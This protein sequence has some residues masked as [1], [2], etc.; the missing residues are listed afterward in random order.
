MEASREI[1]ERSQE[2]LQR[3]KVI[4]EA[5]KENAKRKEEEI[6]REKKKAE[7]FAKA[8]EAEEK[9]GPKDVCL[10]PQWFALRCCGLHPNHPCQ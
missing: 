6:E 8:R 3:N 1:L 5:D 2:E 9:E 10:C 7:E 4:E